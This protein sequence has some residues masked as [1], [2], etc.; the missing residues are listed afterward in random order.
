MRHWHVVRAKPH[1]EATV[2]SHLSG[3]GWEAY[4]PAT[5]VHP[6]NPRAARERAYF[7]GYLFVRMDSEGVGIGRLRWIPASLGLLEFGGAAATVP[8]AFIHRLKLRIEAI[9]AAGGLILD[10]L[11]AGDRVEIISGP[12]T[13]YEAVF[14]TRLR[15]SERVRVFLEMLRRRVAVELNTGD[16]R[17]MGH[18]PHAGA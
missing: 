10:G 8:D 6:V 13:G 4:L 1:R 7:P 17:K 3:H 15:D 16:L 18:R 5:R 11:N 2:L 12:L 14:D 9:R